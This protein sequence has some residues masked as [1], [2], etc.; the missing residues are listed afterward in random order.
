MKTNSGRQL[1]ATILFLLFLPPRI[2]LG[3]VAGLGNA[4]YVVFFLL[5]QKGGS[6]GPANTPDSLHLHFFLRNSCFFKDLFVAARNHSD[7]VKGVVLPFE[8]GHHLP[9]P[10]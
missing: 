3:V 2:Y 8:L 10:D 5:I 4:R 1:A 7:T 9:L 6:H